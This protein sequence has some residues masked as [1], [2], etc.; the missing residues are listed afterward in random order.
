M[1]RIA[2]EH[3]DGRRQAGE[4]AEQGRRPAP[5]RAG[6]VRTTG[7]PYC[8]VRRSVARQGAGR[9]DVTAVTAVITTSP[10]HPIMAAVRL[11]PAATAPMSSAPMAVPAS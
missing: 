11:D 5:S 6:G 9:A 2:D 3:H 4:Q 7:R 10:A 1:R 8:C